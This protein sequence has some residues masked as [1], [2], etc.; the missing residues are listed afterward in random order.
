MKIEI[1][2][3]EWNLFKS[4][5]VKSFNVM[6]KNWEVT[7]LD[8][9]TPLVTILSPS[10]LNIVYINENGDKTEKDFAIWGGILEVSNSNAKLLIDVLVS[11]DNLD[12]NEAEKAKLEAL[13]LM[14]KYKNSKDKIDMEHFIAAED[15]LLKSLVQLKLGNLQK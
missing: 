11:A 7:I 6:T 4:E 8:N 13:K 3:F 2:S 15:M 1:L 9:H 5:T 12:V 10:I 14:D